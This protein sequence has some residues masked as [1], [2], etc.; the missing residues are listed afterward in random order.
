MLDLHN[1]LEPNKKDIFNFVEYNQRPIQIGAPLFEKLMNKLKD[2]WPRSHGNY[3]K[4][5]YELAIAI[6]ESLWI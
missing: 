3:D 1:L 6:V 2:D 5:H 4:T